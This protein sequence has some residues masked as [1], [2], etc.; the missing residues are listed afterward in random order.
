MVR[1]AGSDL[2]AF[3]AL[4]DHGSKDGGVMTDK[5]TVERSEDDNIIWVLDASGEVV[6][7]LD[8]LEARKLMFNLCVALGPLPFP[9]D[10]PEEET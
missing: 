5:P 2:G 3:C 4:E 8:E 10:Q 1:P 6:L 9:Q 7:I